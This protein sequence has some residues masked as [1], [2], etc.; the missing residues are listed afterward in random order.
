V[1][2]GAKRVM[3]SPAL[4]AFDLATE[5]EA[6]RAAY[7]DTDFGRGCLTARNLVRAGV[8]LVEVTLD[9]WDTHEDN[10]GRVKKL[11]QA[12]DPAMSALV[13]DLDAVKDDHG[14]PLSQSTVVLWMGDF[15]R[16]PRINGKDG[17]DHYPKAFSAVVAG[18][19]IKA[20]VVGATDPSGEAPVGKSFEVADLVATAVSAI[21]LSPS[22]EETSPIGR[23]IALTNSGTPISP[24][25][26]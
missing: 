13:R 1:Y 7:G 20:G 25:R 3:A 16:T 14:K 12:L 5:S 10:F 26:P 2:S 9:G 24:L 4:R 18:A 23:P 8:R 15:G 21:G 11:L 19:G 22:E 17:R 6:T